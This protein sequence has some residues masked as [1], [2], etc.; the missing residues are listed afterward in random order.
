MNAEDYKPGDR[1][2]ADTIENA[3]GTVI[4]L[5]TCYDGWVLVRVKF[6]KPIA[7]GSIYETQI[8]EYHPH[9]VK[10]IEQ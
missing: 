6:D 5:T 8:G 9:A 3:P 10:L 4:S 1:V 2:L 7:V